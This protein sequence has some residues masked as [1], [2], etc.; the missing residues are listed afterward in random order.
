MYYALVIL[1]ILLAI[2]LIILI[3]LQPHE[4]E[5]MGAVFGGSSGVETFLGTKT[6]TV[7]W[8]TTVTLG[9]LFIFIAI[10][11]NLMPHPTGESAVKNNGDG[12]R[13]EE[14]APAGG[15]GS[16]GD[17]PN[18]SKASPEGDSGSS[19]KPGGGTGPTDGGS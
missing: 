9:C 18:G 19:S 3:L 15:S 1:E 13:S 17:S 5:G 6:I 10:L 7:L 14:Q 12:T 2:V 8:K 16:D 11:L 4:G